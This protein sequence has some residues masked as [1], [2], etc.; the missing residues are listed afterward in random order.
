MC[1]S[2]AQRNDR[3]VRRDSVQLKHPPNRFAIIVRQPKLQ[4][5]FADRPTRKPQQ[6]QVALD[7][8][9]RRRIMDRVRQQQIKSSI[10]FTLR[11]GN[12]LRVRNTLS[13]AAENRQDTPNDTGP[14]PTAES[15]P[16]SNRFPRR[17]PPRKSQR[18][19]HSPQ[20]YRGSAKRQLRSQTLDS[21]GD[22][23][24]QD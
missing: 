20:I 3:I 11:S 13:G 22:T 19:Q 4:T 17:W 14:R 5:F 16:R 1:S 15:K 23:V 24:R 2:H 7:L 18:L 9:F 10:H 8:M 6:I 21:H 12:I